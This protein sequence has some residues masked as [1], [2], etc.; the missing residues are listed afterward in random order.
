MI[1]SITHWTVRSWT[2]S[3]PTHL[4][5]SIWDTLDN[6]AVLDLI[7][8]PPKDDLWV[9]PRSLALVDGLFEI[10]HG[11]AQ[12]LSLAKRCFE[13]NTY[14][15]LSKKIKNK[16]KDPTLL[17]E[18]VGSFWGFCLLFSFSKLILYKALVLG[19]VL[20]LCCLPCLPISNFKYLV[21]WTITNYKKAKCFAIKEYSYVFKRTSMEA[22]QLFLSPR[23]NIMCLYYCCRRC[24][25]WMSSLAYVWATIYTYLEVG[26]QNDQY[27]I[28]CS[29]M[30]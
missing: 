27:E 24:A 10:L 23:L 28:L 16:N 1:W 5:D 20:G 19:N 9:K 14:S 26:W 11:P 17:K 6:N 15:E 21:N 8:P 25:S 18:R 22:N 12:S 4:G 7:W 30:S 3:S 13:S 29:F 2:K